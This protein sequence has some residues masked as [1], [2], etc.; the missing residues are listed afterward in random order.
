[1]DPYLKLRR[2]RDVG[3]VI[4][5]G[6]T[7]WHG[8]K[9]KTNGMSVENTKNMTLMGITKEGTTNGESMR[10]RR[11]NQGQCEREQAE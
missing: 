5:T 4:V 1:M 10:E 2:R 6:N 3:A 8:G 7:E 11:K 9:V